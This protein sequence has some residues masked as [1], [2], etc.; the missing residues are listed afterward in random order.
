MPFIDD[1]TLVEDL[2]VLVAAVVFYTGFF[3]IWHWHKKDLERA[4]V[5]LREGASVLG[6]LGGLL[7]ILAIWGEF[8]WPLPGAYN[9]YFYDP[10]FML[11][12]LLLAFGWAVRARLPTHIVGMLSLVVGSGVIYYGGRA[13]LLGL[14][15][16]PF[17]TLLLYVGF[18][19]LAILAYPV[20]LFLDWGVTGPQTPGV[21][22][23]VA[24]PV[25]SH[26]RLWF[27]ILAFFMLVAV[28]AGVAAIAYGF[29]SVWA[30]LGSPP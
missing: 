14:T 15:K 24:N 3:V 28:L 20:T 4:Q 1:L 11:A 30:H 19:T 7:A 12:F 27:A 22:P 16:E 6:L 10:L 18:G 13:Y 17:E 5:H 29:T 9:I 25:E 26:R 2:L 21:A 8:F 23:L